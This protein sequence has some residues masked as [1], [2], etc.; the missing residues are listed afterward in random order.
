[1]QP[2]QSQPTRDLQ[3]FFVVVVVVVVVRL[4]SFA[5]MLIQAPTSLSFQYFL[6]SCFF[7][8]IHFQPFSTR[9]TAAFLYRP[10]PIHKASQNIQSHKTMQFIVLGIQEIQY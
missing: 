8:G 10:H 3:G 2:S 9:A 7:F 1:M 6:F 5:F 4:F